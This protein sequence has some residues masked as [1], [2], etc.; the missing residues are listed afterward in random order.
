MRGRNA[1][2][3]VAL[4]AVVAGCNGETCPT[5]T[6]KVDAIAGSC[7]QVT[8]EPVRYPVRLCPT[9]NQI[10]SACDVEISGNRV[11]LDPRVETCDA[12]TSCPPTCEANPSACTFAAPAPGEYIVEAYDPGTGSTQTGTLVVVASGPEF[13]DF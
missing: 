7:Q 6:P 4:A 9:C 10:V 13:C 3:A 5:E 1:V 2:V 11:F 8:N 12:S